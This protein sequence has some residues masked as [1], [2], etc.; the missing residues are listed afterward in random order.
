MTLEELVALMKQ[1][2]GGGGTSTSSSVSQ[3]FQDPAYL[4]YLERARQDK[5][6]KD[7][8]DHEDTL[9]N[10]ELS[11]QKEAWLQKYQQVQL[12]QGNSQ[13]TNDTQRRIDQEQQYQQTLMFDIARFNA[14]QQFAVDQ[15]NQRRVEVNDARREQLAQNI[16]TLASSA[17]D[18]G[19]L[20]AYL[21]ANAGDVAALDRSS[22]S[23]KSFITDSSLVP[24]EVLL[25]AK[26]KADAGPALASFKPLEFP[27]YVQP[28]PVRQDPFVQAMKG[29]TQPA[30]SYETTAT[31]LTDSGIPEHWLNLWEQSKQTS[32]GR[33]TDG[34]EQIP[35]AAQGGIV[36]GPVVVGEDKKTSPEIVFPTTA[37]GVFAVLNRQ[38]AK[39]V[40]IDTKQLAKSNKSPKAADGG[41]F[42]TDGSG[43]S[44][45][46]DLLGGTDVSGAHDF[47]TNAVKRARAGTSYEDGRPVTAVGV[48]APG[49]DPL[50]QQLAASIAS[51]QYGIPEDLFIRATRQ[52]MAP[53]MTERPISRI[54]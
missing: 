36:R 52:V 40:G 47:L 38:Q 34:T 23:G 31:S 6:A 37:A 16:G 20:A 14:Q 10:Y 51:M 50:A 9:Q 13:I 44:I 54:R 19:K 15:E 4:A 3:S 1:L 21:Q 7:Q 41:L 17:G 25:D 49:T 11:K 53:Y 22:T 5:I 24:L 29:T 12:D 42:A 45:W 43:N 27:R 26:A 32:T 46:S 8:R 48:S 2:K 39:K 35:A 28:A 30:P 33:A 18:R